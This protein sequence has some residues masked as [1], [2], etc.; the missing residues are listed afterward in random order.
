MRIKAEQL[1]NELKK[2]LLPLYLVTGDEPLLVQEALD[3]IRLNCKKQGFDE[4]KILEVDRKF[5]WTS[6]NEEANT[7]SLFA[8]KT[9]TELRLGKSKPGTPG[10]KAFQQY[11]DNL[12]EDKILLI[13]ADKLDASTLKSKWCSRLDQT[14]AIIQIWPI[15]L[16][17]M[18]RWIAQRA[19]KMGLNLARDAVSLLSDR[20]EGNL[21]AAQQELE[22]LKLLHPDSSVEISTEDVLESVSD[23]SRYDVFNLTDACLTGKA[24]QSAKIISHLRLEGVEVT[25]VLWALSKEIRLLLNLSHALSK[26]QPLPA[27]FKQHRIIQK[28]QAGLSA[29]AQKHSP[30]K[31]LGLLDQCKK[32]DDLIKGVEKGISPWDVLTDITLAIAKG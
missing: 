15:N 12:P 14:G 1:E 17:E 18:P 11:C 25:F 28:R 31:L 23:A 7:L 22:K 5:D 24:K 32:V 8:E 16:H 21:L 6:L 30:Q 26:G 10:A 2:K 19:N 3:S 9:L 20:L 13:C 29:A 27:L 4:R